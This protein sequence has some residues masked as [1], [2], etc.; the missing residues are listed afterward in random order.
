MSSRNPRSVDS[1]LVKLGASIAA[2]DWSDILL[3]LSSSRCRLEAWKG[4]VKTD[5][6]LIV[7]AVGTVGTQTAM[8]WAGACCVGAGHLFVVACRVQPRAP[9]SIEGARNLGLAP[10]HLSTLYPTQPTDFG[11]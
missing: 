1:P 6:L 7:S 10:S 3:R 9:I 2:L 4:A 8:R 5:M 11:V